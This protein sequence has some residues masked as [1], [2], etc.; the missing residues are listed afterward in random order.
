ML[1]VDDP[2]LEHLRDAALER[3]ERQASSTLAAAADADREPL[4]LDAAGDV[5]AAAPEPLWMLGR[6]AYWNLR[7]IFEGRGVGAGEAS[8]LALRW[9]GEAV[10]EEAGFELREIAAALRVSPRTVER[11]RRRL[12]ALEPVFEAGP[13]PRPPVPAN[14]G[15][16]G[17]G[18]GAA[19]LRREGAA[20]VSGGGRG[21]RGACACGSDIAEG[22]QR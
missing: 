22:A 3:V 6:S 8:S 4:T 10:L 14:V 15:A 20:G 17:A 9:A 11:D 2:G 18:D 5:A 21:E 1:A 7:L 12:R 19:A 13:W 16:A